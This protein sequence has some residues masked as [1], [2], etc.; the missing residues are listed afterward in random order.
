MHPCIRIHFS[1]FFSS[2]FLYDR[3][4]IPALL[5]GRDLIGVAFT[6]SGKTMCFSLPAIMMALEQ[7]L[8]MPFVTNEGPYALVICPI[9]E[10]A[11]QT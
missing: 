9:R 1:F 2:F 3:Q 8:R 11:R 6:G 5:S 7:E 10:L 4:G